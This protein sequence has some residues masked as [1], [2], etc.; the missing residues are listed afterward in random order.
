MTNNK[1][2]K[3]EMQLHCG[4]VTIDE[5]YYIIEDLIYYIRSNKMQQ[6]IADVTKE[7]VS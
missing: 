5:M 7:F 1:L 3:I 4:Q 6:T 2:D